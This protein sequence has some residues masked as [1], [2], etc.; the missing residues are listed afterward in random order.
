M[1]NTFITEFDK[2]FNVIRNIKSKKVDINRYDWIIYDAEVYKDG[3]YNKYPEIIVTSNFYYRKI[4][5]LFSNL[6]SLS[7]LELF[8]LKK[9]YKDLNTVQHV[10]I[11]K[12]RITI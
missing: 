2:D 5:N 12:F 4:K 10:G 7:L 11:R 9:N 8:Q 3:S 6:S 1:I